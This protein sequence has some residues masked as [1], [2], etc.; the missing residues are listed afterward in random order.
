MRYLEC[1]RCG[2][3]YE[4]SNA[5][6]RCSYCDSPLIPRI[7]GLSLAHI[8]MKQSNVTSG[9]WYLSDVLVSN[10]K[11]RVSLGEGLTPL[12]SMNNLSKEYSLGNILMKD[13]SRNPTGTFIDRGSAVAISVAYSLGYRKVS[14]ASLGDLGVSVSAYARRSGMKSHV[15]LPQAVIPS[16]AYQTLILADKVDF[17]GSYEEAL[18]KVMKYRRSFPITPLNPYLLDGY[19]TLCYEV[20]SQLRKAPDAIIIPIG[21]GALLTTFWYVLKDLGLKS[22][23]IGVRGSTASPILRD[24]Y[25]EKP[26]FS[27]VIKE[28][29]EE[30]EGLIIEVCESDVFNAMKE[31]ARCEGILL[32]PVGASSL[33]ALMKLTLKG[34]LSSKSLVVT[35]ATGGA[36]RDTSI[37]RLLSEG[38]VPQPNGVKIGFTKSKILELL[39]SKGPLHPYAIWKLLKDTYDIKISL[40]SLYQHMEELEKLGFVR[41]S[42]YSRVGKRIRKIYEV[43][44]E[45]INMIR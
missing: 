35:I 37:L 39:I 17:V 38:K 2:K 42:G 3:T 30:S 26:L 45:G 9:I 11:Y 15:L 44:P 27:D 1:I 18:N 25:V 23:I 43:T 13:E 10:P 33:A 24:I 34:E 41:V 14:V 21:D 29:I 6:L 32:E 19:R 8:V 20:I 5:I 12:I 31:L 28:V 36:L 16:K 22:M 4:P 7:K 40:R